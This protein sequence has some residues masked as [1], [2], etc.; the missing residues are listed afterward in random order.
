MTTEVVVLD[1][2]VFIS[3]LRH[4]QHV[5]RAVGRGGLIRLSAVVIAELYRGATERVEQRLVDQLVRNHPVLTPTAAD[6]VESGRLLRRLNVRH[7]LGPARLRALHF[8]A[9]I[10]LTA[11]RHGALLVT[12]DVTDFQLLQPE[13]GCRVEY[14]RA[15]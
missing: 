15:E 10:A 11:R 6:W 12:A 5:E 7:A 4:G 8:D 9:L 1:T 2:S 14:W 3:L 13:V